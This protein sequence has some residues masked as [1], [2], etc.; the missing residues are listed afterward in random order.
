L[1]TSGDLY[2]VQALAESR[3]SAL[4]IAIAIGMPPSVLLAAG[5]TVGPDRSEYDLAAR[6]AGAGIELVPSPKLGLPVPSSTEVVI[7]GEILPGVRR[8]EGPFGEWMG[9]YV[10]ITDNHVFNIHHVYARKNAIFYAISAGSAE[11]AVMIALPMAGTIYTHVRNWVPAVTDV[12]CFPYTQ[13]C[14][15][16]IKKQFEGQQQK[17]LLTA[18]GAE[19]N[20]VLYCVIVDDDVDIHNWHDVLWAMATRSRPDRSILI[21]GV[22]SFSRDPHAIHWGRLAID[23]TKP[24]AAAADFER[25][26]TPGASSIK[27][28]DYA[29]P[30]G[31]LP[32]G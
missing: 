17:A 14:V 7:E 29:K 5:T 21:P 25:K 8:P 26:R 12:T 18:L 4:P 15:L 16:Q 13:Y 27:W 24:L 23:A 30:A 2:R 3:G 32:F 20:H 1:L 31:P 22:P 19:M 6:I 11:E 28:E 10:P 9:Y